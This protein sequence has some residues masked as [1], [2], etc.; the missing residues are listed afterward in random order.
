MRTNSAF[1][2][3]LLVA[4]LAGAAVQTAVAAPGEG[5]SRRPQVAKTPPPPRPEP[6]NVTTLPL[7]PTAPSSEQGACSTATNPRGTGC[8]DGS[9]QGILEGPA[10]MWDSRHVLLAINFAGA[11]AEPA[12]AS[13]YSGVQVIAVKTD[14]GRFANGD[15][16]KCLTCGVPAANAVGANRSR[17]DG[18]PSGATHILLDHPQAFPDDKRILA[19]TN[20][21]DCTPYKL[22]DAACTPDRVRIH[23]IR[24][25]MSADG[26]GPGG[27]MRELRLNPDGVHLGWSHLFFQPHFGQYAAMGRLVFNPAPKT[28]TPLAP[29]YELEQVTWLVGPTTEFPF[30]VDPQNPTR[31]LR[32]EPRYVIGEFRGWSGDGRSAIGVGFDESGN[33]DGYLTSLATGDS[34]RL[35]ADPAYTDP[36]KMSADDRWN[37]VMDARQ[38][39]RYNWYAGMR[40]VPPLTDMV[41]VGL[42]AHG[43][44]VAHRRF[45]QPFLIDRY[46]DRGD[47]H[48]Q[49]LNAGPGTPGSPSDPNWN[50][51][52]DPAWA[53]DGTKVVYWQALATAPACG[54]S[55]QAPC[56]ISTEPGGRRTRLM[57]A[58]LP[59]RRPQPVTRVAPISDDVPWGV[60]YRPGDPLPKRPHIPAGSY[61]MQGRVNGTAKV[62]VKAL[63]DQSGLSSVSVAYSDYTDDGSHVI[64][65]T[66]SQALADGPKP[67]VVLQSDLRSSGVQQAT[68]RTTGPG[69]FIYDSGMSM[70]WEGVL[71]TTIDGKAYGPPQDLD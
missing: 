33:F 32:T 71:T 22:T 35:T 36:M 48:G 28:G 53:P 26:A 13:I 21:V 40:G 45:F 30:Q 65:G 51:R 55:H 52:A 63:P 68:K 1:S 62:E 24:W 42:P 58:T 60:P 69:L 41:N 37:V 38:G 2:A 12:A 47:Y 34:S 56:P 25:N 16:W 57:L 49:Q 43:W 44:R 4:L 29:R 67:R 5:V 70:S 3:A 7:P 14:G 10:Y 11:P 27:G 46:G 9:D 19:G 66:E 61:T 15:A 59:I 54:G 6:I 18:G 39:E 64:N 31:L 20:V 8:I 23:P 17:G 50:G